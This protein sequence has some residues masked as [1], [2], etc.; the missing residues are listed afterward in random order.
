[1]GL[2]R[3]ASMAPVLLAWAS[4]SAKTPEAAAEDVK[5]RTLYRCQVAGVTT[6]S[7]RP[8]GTT[9]QERALAQAYVLQPGGIN[10]SEPPVAVP[11][12]RRKAPQKQEKP[13]PDADLPSPESQRRHA[14]ACRRIQ[15]SLRD[16]RSKMRA[17]Y[18]AKEGERLRNRQQALD[19]K[20]RAERCG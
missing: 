1:M 9:L 6:F 11:V 7:D 4:F 3:I 2:T 20:R 15:V 8:C 16:I 17:G 13:S 14:E 18:S 5:A 12:Q 10:T 19:Q